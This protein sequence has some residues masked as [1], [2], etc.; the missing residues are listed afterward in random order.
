MAG[1]LRGEQMRDGRFF[2]EP[3]V[4]EGIALYESRLFAQK[5]ADAAPRR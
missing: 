3:W 2:K 1:G 5:V 4:Q